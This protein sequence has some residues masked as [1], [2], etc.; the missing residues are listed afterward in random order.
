[1]D[2]SD[3]YSCFGCYSYHVSTFVT[4]NLFLQ[5]HCAE[6]WNLYGISKQA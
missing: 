1:M 2:Y 5:V 3:Y 6:R 4:S